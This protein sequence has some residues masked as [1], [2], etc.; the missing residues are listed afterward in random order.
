MQ[1]LD[2]AL[3]QLVSRQVVSAEEARAYA[4]N[5]EAFR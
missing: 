3:Q 1:T 4:A 2:Q 5:K